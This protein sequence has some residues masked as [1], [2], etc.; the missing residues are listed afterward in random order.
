[1]QLQVIEEQQGTFDWRGGATDEAQEGTLIWPEAQASVGDF[2][3]GGESQDYFCFYHSYDYMGIDIQDVS[4]QLPP[5]CQK[6]YSEIENDKRV[7]LFEE[8][9]GSF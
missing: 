5:I 8:K 1:M 2:I 6:P 3:W 7:I 4:H 9:T